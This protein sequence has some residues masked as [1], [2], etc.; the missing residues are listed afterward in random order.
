MYREPYDALIATIDRLQR[1][2]DD[3]APLRRRPRGRLLV[4]VTAMSV[5]CAI[6]C[7]SALGA[8]RAHVRDL[9]ERLSTTRARLD[10]KTQALGQCESFAR[11]S[12]DA[13]RQYASAIDRYKTWGCWEP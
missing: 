12:V 3:V 8:S 4:F 11:D 13:Q 2:L 10:A 5:L 6:L 7:L 9:E 1:E